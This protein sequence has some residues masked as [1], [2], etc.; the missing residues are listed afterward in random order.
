[1]FPRQSL[2][3]AACLAT[4][5]AL[6]AQTVKAPDITKQPTLYVVP[7][8]H[9]DTQ[10]RWEFPQT[11]SEYLLKTMRVNFDLIDKYPHYVFN[12]TGS[13]RYRL[14]KEYF[15]ADYARVKKYVAAGRWFP[16]GSSVEE[17]DVNMPS[18]EA[19]IRQVLYGNTYFRQEFGKAS[20]E[21]MLP[22]CFGFPAS[23]PSL[24]AHAGVKGFSTQKLSSGWQPAPKV[25]GPD[26]P[27]QT[28]MGIPF[29]VGLWEG[30]DGKTILAALNPGGYGSNIST[31]LSKEPTAGGGGR[32]GEDNW[33]TR[34]ELDG[35]V[36]GVYAD[37]KYV[38]TGDTGGATAEY[39]ARILEAMVTKSETV[40]G[41]A[42]GRGGGRGGA[43][44]APPTPAV[45][46]RV[47]EGPLT[48]IPA[49][50]DQMFLDIQ[51][52]MT[53]RMPRWKGD[54]ELINHS[55]GSLTSEAI[56][57][58]WNRKNEILADEAEKA[59]LAAAWLRSGRPYPQQRLNDAW[60]LVMGGHFHD[61]AAGTATPRAYEF[62]QND[63]V[64]AMNQF[65]G[66]LTDATQTVASALDTQTKGTAVV[67]Y[68][69]LNIE[70]E[71]VVEATIALP[72]DTK[73]VRVTGPDGK[74]V[75]S[76]VQGD[77]V[78]FLAKAPS[79]GYAVYDVEPAAEGMPST[80]KVN[81]RAGGGRG[82]GG[83][84][85][86]AANAAPTSIE[87]DRY[88]VTLDNNG[89]VAGIFDKLVDRELLSAPMRLAISN[90]H[91]SQWPAWNMDFDQE[92]APPRAFVHGVTGGV[93]IKEN[94]PARVTLEVTRTNTEG[95][96]FVQ[97]VSL[98]AGD[99]GNRVEFGEVIDWKTLYSN[100]K[101]TFPLAASNEDATYNW[102][103][104][105]VRR[106]SASERQFEVASHQ[107]IDLTDRGGSYGAT[108]LTDCKNGSDKPNNNTLRLTLVRTP[109][110]DSSYTDQ[111]NQDWGHHEMMFGIAGHRGDWRDGQTD[112]QAYR[113]NQPL[114]AFEAAKHSGELGKQFSLVTVSNP[115]I[116]IMALKKAELSDEVVL[117]M[118]ELD[119]R[120]QQN[121]VVKFAGAI[122][123]AREMNGQELP[124]AGNPTLA[125]GT[126]VTNFTAYQP[127]TFALKLAAATSK[128]A[129]ASSKPV[130]LTYDLSV[131]SNDDTKTVGGFDSKGNAIPAEMLPATIDFGPAQFKLAPAG[132]G[133]A[134]AMVAKGQ[135]LQLP[136]GQF[137]R[138]YLLAAS[139]DGDQKATFKVGD[140]AVDL[141]IENWGGFIGQ[142]DTRI[143]NL[144]SRDWASSANHAVWPLAPVAQDAA[145]GRSEPRY[146]EDFVGMAPGY[147][148]PA[149]LAWYASHH[150]TAE[151]LNE[152]YQYSYLFA[153]AVDL[154][155]GSKTLT[156]PN[157]DKIRVLA[158]SVTD[159]G[160]L[161]KPAQLLYDT[162]GRTEPAQT[163]R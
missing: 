31:D 59:S 150:H 72:A 69:P 42:G 119:G 45:P 13:N 162:L 70:R 37:Y 104:G 99:A 153:Y 38:G 152:P 118:V 16:A 100:L 19:I 74:Q 112:W 14:M 40:L 133:K 114:I 61:S 63:D 85:G 127:R 55:A 50:A 25:G 121:V 11:I 156:L 2:L 109:G 108:I 30:P 15:P 111:A 9:L 22:D 65:A 1:M 122:Q 62:I 140:K 76:Q 163:P 58:R 149:D 154:P 148:K 8:A 90:D 20:A 24:L 158:V 124:I 144:P 83:R 94:G 106:P 48:V 146:P 97:S 77:K 131:S 120:P 103:L 92:Q 34:V 32:G 73:A 78:L 35:E 47:G 84:G 51:P 115:R 98:S 132:T 128:A 7:Y 136:A 93:R 29:N 157:N 155:A 81:V 26:S 151:G 95:S 89:D 54:L 57:K 125:N 67:V 159:E 33:V 53:T 145:R 44:A 56:H 52:E 129:P 137:N 88:R 102:G 46:V 107:W 160:P 68:N 105:T 80:L 36:T 110:V 87:N 10:W 134:N 18:A 43:N 5:A 6:Q 123:A 17:G 39:T 101:A 161:V 66:V 28:P 27:E 143:W 130:T 82:G 96:H 60:T 71:D 126:L 4:L 49:T 12:W 91:P 135:T 64:I 21:Y 3:A 116:Q 41:A 117:R 138:V 23:L 79:V 142:W 141:N 75:P 113:L 86:A 139:S 147:V